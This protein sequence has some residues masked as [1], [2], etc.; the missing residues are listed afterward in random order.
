MTQRTP[1]ADAAITLC[2]D[3]AKRLEKETSINSF[4]FG[5]SIYQDGTQ[6][7]PERSDIDIVCL[8]PNSITSALARFELMKKLHSAKREIELSMI[9]ILGR[10]VCCEPGVS[11][12]PLTDIELKGDVHKSGVGDFFRVNSFMNLL[13]DVET[14]G[15]PSAGTVSIKPTAAQ[16]M[17][18][19]QKIRNEYL[20]VA[21]NGAGGIKPFD[22]HDPLPKSLL[23]AA[24]QISKYSKLGQYFDVRLGLEE[25]HRTVLE[26]RSEDPAISK[27]F[28]TKIS[29]RR[30]GRGVL[31]PLDAED[32]LLLAEI[33]FD[34]AMEIPYGTPV[35]WDMR[36]LDTVHNDSEVDRIFGKVR[37]V[38]P[39]ARLIGNWPGS[40]IL[41]IVSSKEGYDFLKFLSDRD[42]LGEALGIGKTEITE[43]NDQTPSSPSINYQDKRLSGILLA[44]DDWIP[45]SI[46]DADAEV[47]LR[48]VIG[49]AIRNENLHGDGY[50]ILTNPRIEITPM[51]SA[52]FDFL[53]HWHAGA[54]VSGLEVPVELKKYRNNSTVPQ[55]LEAYF[56]MGKTTIIVVYG[57]PARELDR[58]R[59]QASRAPEINANLIFAF[60]ASS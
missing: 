56:D 14:F 27:L 2:R 58:V 26:R 11:I 4:L 31:S 48:E 38:C 28:D 20:S 22:G 12:I 13:T 49:A 46:F 54:N 40:L 34:N 7:D 39:D 53:V 41:R 37:I 23:R 9:P 1:S 35:T 50:S 60:K 17:A 10:T 55:L 21:A 36:V 8:I 16:A 5:S 32:Q 3:W 33:L 52:K 25:M 47:E 18:Y 59:A 51:R 30:G 44:I 57:I 43:L 19:T 42:V 24:A 6:F 15:I 29:V 45:K